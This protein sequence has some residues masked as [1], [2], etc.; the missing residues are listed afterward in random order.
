[1]SSGISLHFADGSSAEADVVVG[2]DGIHSVVR[3]HICRQIDSETA[4]D[5]RWSGTVV[6]RSLISCSDLNKRWPD[7]H[8]A[9]RE[10]VVV[11]FT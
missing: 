8:R 5:P 3:T 7:G 2:A 9:T 4:C 1:M 11:G 10:P 6:Y